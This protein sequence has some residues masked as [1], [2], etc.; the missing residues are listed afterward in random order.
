MQL[1]KLDN[2]TYEIISN[3]YSECYVEKGSVCV[4]DEEVGHVY[5]ADYFKNNTHIESNDFDDLYSLHE[6]LRD[7][8]C[9]SEQIIEKITFKED[10]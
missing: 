1:K 6:Y 4:G 10:K 9:I 3:N 7:E 8:M 5:Y 2:Y